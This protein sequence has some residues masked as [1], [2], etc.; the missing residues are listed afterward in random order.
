MFQLYCRTSAQIRH[1]GSPL[2]R[3]REAFLD[4]RLSLGTKRIYVRSL[5]AT[6]LQVVRGLQLNELRLVTEAEIEM[7]GQQWALDSQHHSYRKA[8]TH[9][10]HVFETAARMFLRFHGVLKQDAPLI[11]FERELTQYLGMQ[12]NER[13]LAL[14]TV[15]GHRGHVGRFLKWVSMRHDSLS[16][17]A[18][19]DVLDYLKWKEESCARASIFTTAQPL[20]L[21]FDYGER[22]GWLRPN[23]G[24]VLVFP[25]RQRYAHKMQPPA[26]NE[27]RQLLDGMA[28]YSPSRLRDR[29]MLLLCAV[30]GLRASEV[31]RLRLQDLDWR[32][33]TITVVR[34][35]HGGVQIYPLQFEVGD[36]IRRYLISGRP[37]CSCRAVFVTLYRPFR[38]ILPVSLTM[39]ARREMEKAGVQSSRIGTHAFRHAAATELLR[40]GTPLRDIAEFLGHKDLKTVSVYVQCDE[41]SLREAGDFSLGAIR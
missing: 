4:H 24:S 14:S 16:S 2:V 26:W 23:L 40:Q 11:P 1:E 5:G 36:A 34:S 30:Y 32:E 12:R 15:N 39:V 35:K 3:E 33:E 10:K 8:G 7:A 29:A 18:I 21:F 31:A 41:A 37:S 17:I 9:S 27:V 38:P 20:R 22:I 19:Q 28:G 25:M 13:S 6:L